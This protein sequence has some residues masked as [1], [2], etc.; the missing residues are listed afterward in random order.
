M[1]DAKPS[2]KYVGRIETGVLKSYSGLSR[3]DQEPTLI[4]PA[5]T[6]SHFAPGVIR[7]VGPVLSESCVVADQR[8]LCSLP[9]WQ[10]FFA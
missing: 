3:Q 6:K 2:I 10:S 7:V 8:R 9:G 5:V 4:A 1:A